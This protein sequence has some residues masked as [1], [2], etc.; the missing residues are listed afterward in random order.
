[1]FLP[2]KYTTWYM[3]IISQAR[4]RCKPS[5]S[6]KHHVV[7]R[8]LGG[9]NDETNLVC[10][11]PREHFICHLLLARMTEGAA[12]YKMTAAI[13]L[14][15]KNTAKHLNRSTV[16]SKAYDMRV[17]YSRVSFSL[18]HRTKLSAKA[19]A[20]KPQPKQPETKEKHRLAISRPGVSTHTFSSYD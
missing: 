19:K 11:T 9:S 5:I 6:E 14:M 8:S 7:P 1:M 10:L 16:T 13:C 17:A 18:E 15:I 12:R 4:Q 3:S 20:R 2:N